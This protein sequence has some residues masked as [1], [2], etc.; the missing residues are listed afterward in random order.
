[1]E[2]HIKKFYLTR[3]ANERSRE[4][5]ISIEI[6]KS[7]VK[8]PELRKQLRRGEHDGFVFKFEKSVEGKKIIVVAEIKKDTCWLISAFEND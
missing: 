4:R 3:H 7:I 6:M 2:M 1:M 8:Y 5:S